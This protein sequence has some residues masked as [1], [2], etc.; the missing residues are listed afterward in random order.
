M[1]TVAYAYYDNPSMLALH[2]T[3]WAAYPPEINIIVVDDAS[4]HSPALD[5]VNGLGLS[6]LKVYRIAED[7]PWN[8]NGAR[9]LAM[10]VCETEWACL[11]DMDHLLPARQAQAML[12]MPREPSCYYVPRRVW[13]DGNEHRRH[14]NSYL[15]QTRKFFASGGYDEDFC[16]YYGSDGVFRRALDMVATRVETDAFTTILYE[17]HIEDAN[18]RVFGRKGTP[19]H[20]ALNPALAR[21]RAAGGYRAQNPLRFSWERVL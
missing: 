18:T 6:A 20:A 4:P 11:L 9:N 5:V 3:E 19:Y 14:P 13:P 16:G 10:A 15:L 7:I 21:K 12:S 1:I 8:Q 17:G 2:C